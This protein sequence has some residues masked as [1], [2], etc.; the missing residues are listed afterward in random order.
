MVARLKMEVLASSS[1][2]KVLTFFLYV[3]EFFVVFHIRLDDVDYI[4][5]INTIL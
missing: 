5:I 1:S 4:C 3:R 2:P